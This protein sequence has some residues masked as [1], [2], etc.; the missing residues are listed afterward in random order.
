MQSRRL[1]TAAT[2]CACSPV[3]A[4][5]GDVSRP[6]IAAPPGRTIE[7]TLRTGIIYTVPPPAGVAG[8]RQPNTV[9]ITVN[10]GMA[11]GCHGPG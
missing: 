11:V 7:A 1:V 4:N 10:N 9:T 5:A 6:T 3:L 8:G 2:F